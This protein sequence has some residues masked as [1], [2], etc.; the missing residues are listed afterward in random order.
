M[1]GGF[2]GASELESKHGAFKN[3]GGDRTKCGMA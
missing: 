1:L 2:N 3:T